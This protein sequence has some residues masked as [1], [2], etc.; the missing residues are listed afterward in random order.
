MNAILEVYERY[1]DKDRILSELPLPQEAFDR[2]IL[3]HL[4]QAIRHYVAE[5]PTMDPDCEVTIDNV[6]DVCPTCGRGGKPC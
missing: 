4:W 1:K 6:K 2:H 3:Y 5:L